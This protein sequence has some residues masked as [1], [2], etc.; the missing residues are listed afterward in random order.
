M[1][2]Q[3]LIVLL[4]DCYETAD[5]KVIF[6]YLA[7]DIKRVSM[8]YDDIV[9]IEAFIDY[10][11][12]KADQLQKFPLPRYH[13]A[14][15]KYINNQPSTFSKL[16]NNLVHPDSKIGDLKPNQNTR[17]ALWYPEGEH[18]LLIQENIYEEADVVI[19]L[20]LNEQGLISCLSLS[21]TKLYAYDLLEDH[22]RSDVQLGQAAVDFINEHYRKLGYETHAVPYEVDI[23]PHL[24][25]IK[26][27]TKFQVVV[28]VDRYPFSGGINKDIELF[29]GMRSYLSQCPI[30]LVNVQ[31]ESLGPHKHRF[32]MDHP[33]QC[34]ILSIQDAYTP[35]T[36]KENA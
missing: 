30:K 25:V 14:K 23:F 2:H 20:E 15:L 10:L 34:H 11:N 1:N 31:V 17:F 8:W 16:E 35:Y 7:Q 9:G 27:N 3:E 19:R 36:E 6:P 5:F 13:L 33:I 28:L 22:L 32:E 26:Q 4:K 29:L 12:M 21:D 24:H 18:I